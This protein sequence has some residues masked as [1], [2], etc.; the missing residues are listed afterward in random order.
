MNLTAAIILIVTA[1]IGTALMTG[2]IMGRRTPAGTVKPPVNPNEDAIRRLL[3]LAASGIEEMEGYNRLIIRKLKVGQGKDVLKIAEAGRAV[4]EQRE[5]FEAVFDEMVL[6]L[7]PDF[8]GRVNSLLQPGK[9][10]TAPDNGR[11]S[12]ELRLVAFMRLG[13]DDASRISRLTGLTLNTIYTYRNKIK[14]RAIDRAN[15]D[16]AIM[17]IK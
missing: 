10:L 13:L 2:L 15:L 6:T 5:R 17:A 8:V 3:G 1:I 11:L 9:Q 7:Y 4:R 12:P 14:T 16:R